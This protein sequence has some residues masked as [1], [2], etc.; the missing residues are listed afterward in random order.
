MFT[1]RHSVVKKFH[2]RLIVT[3]SRS[4]IIWQSRCTSTVKKLYP[5]SVREVGEFRAQGREVLPVCK[6]GNTETKE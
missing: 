1:P 2:L 5:R 6:V 4:T 3:I